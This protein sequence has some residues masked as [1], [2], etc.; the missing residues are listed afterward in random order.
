MPPSSDTPIP[1]NRD[2]RH[3]PKPIAAQRAGRCSSTRLHGER[4]CGCAPR[5]GGIQNA[6]AHATGLRAQHNRAAPVRVTPRAAVW[7]EQQV[8]QRACRLRRQPIRSRAPPRP[9]CHGAAR[10]THLTSGTPTSAPSHPLIS[11]RKHS[12]GAPLVYV[13]GAALPLSANDAAWRCAT[14]I[15]GDHC[16]RHTTGMPNRHA[17]RHTTPC[18]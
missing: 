14:K 1:R 11:R 12:V 6:A 4:E 13:M 10:C 8:Q 7:R 18:L 3:Y 16:W 9:P 5:C 2:P 15:W 17:R